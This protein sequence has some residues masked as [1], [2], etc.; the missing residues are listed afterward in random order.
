MLCTQLALVGSLLGLFEELFF[1]PLEPDLEDLGEGGI[2]EETWTESTNVRQG[3]LELVLA[4]ELS[5]FLLELFLSSFGEFLA[6]FGSMMG[7]P[8]EA[9]L[10]LVAV[11][12]LLFPPPKNRLSLGVLT[13]LITSGSTGTVV[14]VMLLKIGF[15]STGNSCTPF[16]FSLYKEA[17]FKNN[18]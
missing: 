18:V 14:M 11:L 7:L 15:I 1:V 10:V 13:G 16:I 12:R 17:L 9:L 5:T 8:P 4:G 6:D 3:D 2:G